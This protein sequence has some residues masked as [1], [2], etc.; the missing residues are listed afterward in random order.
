MSDLSQRCSQPGQHTRWPV[1]RVAKPKLTG[2]VASSVVTPTKR[3]RRHTKSAYGC[4]GGELWGI[5]VRFRIRIRIRIEWRRQT[6]GL[7]TRDCTSAVGTCRNN[8]CGHVL[9]H[10]MY[11]DHLSLE[12]GAAIHFRIRVRDGNTSPRIAVIT[13]KTP[14]IRLRVEMTQRPRSPCPGCLDR[15]SHLLLYLPC[16]LTLNNINIEKSPTH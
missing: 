11:E 15:V 13:C 10:S 7:V 2:C 8:V 1:R 12:R 14:R 4:G 3:G 16:P 5:R 9:V 6:L